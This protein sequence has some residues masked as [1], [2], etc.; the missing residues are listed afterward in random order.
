MSTL[1]VA[2]FFVPDRL[3]ADAALMASVAEHG[4]GNS[5]VLPYF[6]GQLVD[7]T[8]AWAPYA[9]AAKAIGRTVAKESNVKRVTTAYAQRLPGLDEALDAL[10][11]QP[12]RAADSGADSVAPSKEAMD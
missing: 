2:L 6:L 7:L 12:G 9:A 10:L 5:F 4:L 11:P 8:V 3:H 1:Y